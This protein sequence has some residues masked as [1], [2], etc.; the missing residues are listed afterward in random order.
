MSEMALDPVF[1]VF[2]IPLELSA[3]ATERILNVECGDDRYISAVA[4]I[5]GALRVVAR[6]KAANVV[7]PDEDRAKTLLRAHKDLSQPHVVAMLSQHGIRRTK[8]WVSH[9]RYLDEHSSS[10]NTSR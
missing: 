9:Q 1:R 6:A 4:P 8:Q 10:A 7:P 2:D 3:A 5:P